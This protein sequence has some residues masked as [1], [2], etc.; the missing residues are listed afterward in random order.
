MELWRD[1]GHFEHGNK[2]MKILKY[3]DVVPST[4]I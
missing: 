2:V 4:T 3:V 1:L